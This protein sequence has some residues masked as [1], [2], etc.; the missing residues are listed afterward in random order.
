MAL[1]QPAIDQPVD[2]DV[3]EKQVGLWSDAWQRFRRNRLA[4]VGGVIVL[5]LILVALSAPL[6]VQLHLLQPP[7]KQHVE[8]IESGIGQNGYLFGSDE[9][10]RDT[11]SRLMFG[12][13]VSLA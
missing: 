7:N 13:Q 5:F 2:W 6:L 1:A 10:G 8:Y 4:V 9:L 12:S 3:A 11:L